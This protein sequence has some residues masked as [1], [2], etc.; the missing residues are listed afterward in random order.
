MAP[1]PTRQRGMTEVQFQLRLQNPKRANCNKTNRK[2][3]ATTIGKQEKQ[4]QVNKKL[5]NKQ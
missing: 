5:V 3:R 1:K 2:K 4:Q